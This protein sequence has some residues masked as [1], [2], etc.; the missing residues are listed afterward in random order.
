[1]SDPAFMVFTSYAGSTGSTPVIALPSPKTNCF[2]PTELFGQCN[3]VFNDLSPI[4]LASV[5]DG[6]SNT[7]FLA[8]KST[9]VL[10]NLDSVNPHLF[11]KRGW[12]VTGNWGDTLFTTLFPPNAHKKVILQ[13]AAAWA[14]SASSL[15]PDGVN[16][17]MGD[18]SARFIRST[19]QSWPLNRVSGVPTGASVNSLGL[20]VN[21]PPS[22]VWQ[23]LSTRA[24][25]EL[26]PEN[27]Y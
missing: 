17:L 1:M 27:S 18:G 22:G 4:G 8:E 16:V 20:W 25:D 10:K 2:V 12:Y 6:L 14:D 24:G 13:A 26:L 15:H 19:V 11:M 5:T 9:T 3:G 7:I 23:A 21:L